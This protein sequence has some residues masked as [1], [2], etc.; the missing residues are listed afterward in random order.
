MQACPDCKQVPYKIAGCDEWECDCGKP[1]EY[2]YQNHCWNC[3]PEVI[4][5]EVNSEWSKTPGMGL[6]C[7]KC[8]KDL[9]EYKGIHNG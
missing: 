6:V 3:G 2:M 8:G 1:V 7:Y 5:N 9:T 4:I